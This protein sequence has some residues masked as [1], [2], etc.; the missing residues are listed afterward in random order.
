MPFLARFVDR[1][2]TWAPDRAR[3]DALV[4]LGF[5]WLPRGARWNLD[6]AAKGRLSY[7]T[8]S[9]KTV[10]EVVDDPHTALGNV[11]ARPTAPSRS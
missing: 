2:Y 7:R 3:P 9:T 8:G 4:S 6:D 5:E 1:G 10:L 11:A